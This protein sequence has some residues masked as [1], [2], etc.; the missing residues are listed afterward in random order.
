L[1]STVQAPQMRVAP[2]VRSGQVEDV[3]EQMHE[4]QSRLDVVLALGAVNV[5]SN[6]DRQQAPPRDDT[7]RPSWCRPVQAVKN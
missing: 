2:D 5:E 4:E 1:T 6:G 3:A 7:G